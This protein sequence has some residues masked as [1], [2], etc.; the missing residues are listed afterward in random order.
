MTAVQDYDI[1]NPGYPANNQER[2]RYTPV[3]NQAH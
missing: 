2:N 3:C 1:L